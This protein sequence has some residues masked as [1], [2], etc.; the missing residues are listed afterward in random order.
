M[1]PKVAYR[2]FEHYTDPALAPAFAAGFLGGGALIALADLLYLPAAGTIPMMLA[3]LL[4]LFLAFVGVSFLRILRY[5]VLFAHA[6]ADSGLLL[7]LG[8]GRRIRVAWDNVLRVVRHKRSRDA[9][10]A[11]LHILFRPGRQRVLLPPGEGQDALYDFA[12]NL[13]DRKR[14]PSTKPAKDKADSAAGEGQLIAARFS[15]W[16]TVVWAFAKLGCAVAA[17]LFLVLAADKD[18]ALEKAFF[19]AIAFEIAVP[20]WLFPPSAASGVV[21]AAAGPRGLSF[22]SLLFGTRTIRWGRLIT[23]RVTIIGALGPLVVRMLEFYDVEGARLL[24][25]VPRSRAFLEQVDRE[26]GTHTLAMSEATTPAPP[27][28]PTGRGGRRRR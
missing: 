24:M 15:P 26:L 14:K 7:R 9:R 12:V 22:Q 3:A 18:I 20:I 6:D 8:G 5:T 27:R 17:G 19:L 16:P 25:A 21:R 1:S 2:V 10:E 13:L 28:A 23:A 4:A 11:T